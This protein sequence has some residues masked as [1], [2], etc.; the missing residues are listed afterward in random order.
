MYDIG[1]FEPLSATIAQLYLFFT[2]SNSY[3]W[4][5]TKISWTPGADGTK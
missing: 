1:S 4:G 5:C 2:S 3:V